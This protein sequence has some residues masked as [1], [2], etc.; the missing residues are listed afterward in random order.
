[1]LMFI[2]G[3]N[4]ETGTKSLRFGNLLEKPKLLVGG[5]RTLEALTRRMESCAD[6]IP[7]SCVFCTAA[8]SS[9]FLKENGGQKWQ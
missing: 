7:D 1:M 9:E 4:A 5:A 6:Q 2:M 8:A 3:F